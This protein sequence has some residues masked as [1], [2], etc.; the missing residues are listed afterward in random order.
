MAT[1]FIAEV[2]GTAVL[3][4]GILGS[5]DMKN[6]GVGGNLGPFIVGGT[7]LAVGLSLGGP[8]G[9]S[10]NPARDLGPRIFGA[11]VGTTGLFDGMYWLLVPVIG[12]SLVVCWVSSLTT[13]SLPRS[14]RKNKHL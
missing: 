8:S 11:L 14:C 12:H 5:G 6:M 13:G 10:I 9:Y 3:L 1:A 2:I 7:V 4:W